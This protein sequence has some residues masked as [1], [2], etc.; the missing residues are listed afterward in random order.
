[1]L[2]Q[3]QCCKIHNC[4]SFL[5]SQYNLSD[6]RCFTVQFISPQQCYN[7]SDQSECYGSVRQF[8]YRNSTLAR[9]NVTLVGQ[10]YE[11]PFTARRLVRPPRPVSQSVSET[12]L[13][14]KLLD[15]PESFVVVGLTAHGLS[16]YEQLRGISRAQY[17][18]QRQNGGKN[19]DREQKEAVGACRP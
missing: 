12:A 14:G 3:F 8:Q 13:P 19:P 17:C 5:G 10:F 18:S 9:R 4:K 16:E 6:Q 11:N 2:K 15:S 1:M 7:Q